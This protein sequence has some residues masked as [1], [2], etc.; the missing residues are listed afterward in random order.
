MRIAVTGSIATDHL[1]VF[2]GRFA[3]QL[4][5]DHLDQVSLSFLADQLDIRRGGTAGNIALGFAKIG[6]SPVLV[7]G[8][9][10]DFAEYDEFLSS[11]GV[12]TS[13]VYVS[14][15][16]HTARF[17]CTT[18]E[19]QNQIGT[20]YSGAMSDA[21]QIELASV[22]ERVGGFDLVTISPHDPV[23]MLRHTE[24]CRQHGYRFVADVGQQVARMTGDEIRGL[25]DGAAWLFTNEYEHSLLLDKTGW[26]KEDVLARVGSWMTTLGS[27]GARLETKEGE[28][29][30]VPA[31]PA[32]QEVDPTGVGDAFRVGFFA[33]VAWQLSTERSMQF[34]SLLA[35]TVLETLGPQEYEIDPETFV[36]RFADAYGEEA[37]TEVKPFLGRTL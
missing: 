14:E 7:A 11:H 35:T 18:D 21:R 13:G 4:V 19:D 24:E 1:M 26:S 32:K 5:A 31:V 10:R 15:D 22:A 36:R 3:D 37:A 30:T 12:D 16:K 6:M 9:G 8:V 34:G 29:A 2:P 28:V 27:A 17:I 23:A 33:G 25:V 20:F